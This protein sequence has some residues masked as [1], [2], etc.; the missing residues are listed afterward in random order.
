MMD[1]GQFR[2]YFQ[3]NFYYF[4]AAQLALGVVFGAIPLVLGIRRQ[5]AKLG[6]IALVTSI[7]LAL[8]SPL[9][10]LIVAIVFAYFIVR[11][12]KAGE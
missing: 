9:L 6:L 11:Q 3:Q 2:E 4:V 1:Y 8:V 10:C 5:E 7:I 12:P